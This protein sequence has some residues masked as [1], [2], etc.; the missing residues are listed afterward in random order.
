LLSAL[1]EEDID[2]QT[3]KVSSSYS[4]SC[5]VF[6]V[7][8]YLYMR[9]MSW[10]HL[11]PQHTQIG[12]TVYPLRKHSNG[13]IANAAKKLV[14]EW[15][16]KADAKP[17]AN[18]VAVKVEKN[19]AEHKEAKHKVKSEP[20]EKKEETA[21]PP[22]RANGQKFLINKLQSIGKEHAYTH[23]TED[24]IVEM[25]KSVGEVLENA[26]HEECGGEESAESSKAYGEQIK[27]I[28][29]NLGQNIP[30]ALEILTK[31]RPCNQ[32]VKMSK[33]ELAGEE[34]REQME[35]H[36]KEARKENQLDW[37]RKNKK[38]ILDSA[39][40]T[41]KEG[42][43]RCFKCGSTDTEYTQRQTRAADEPMTNFVHCNECGN[44]WKS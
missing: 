8:N 15:K 19:T 13:S 39:G 41:Q 30:L 35:K 23:Y 37:E 12:L 27:S 28:T 33:E 18:K 7:I 16:Q 3:L 29:F 43:F 21:L 32:V 11:S 24:K 5:R 2:A 36:Q 42:Q 14:K 17:T 9:P 25:A 44:R 40:L 20:K 10:F 22:R 34:F 1:S 31:Q 4:T 6:N 26:I 38:Q